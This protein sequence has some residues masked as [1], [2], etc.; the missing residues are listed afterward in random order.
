MMATT[1]TQAKIVHE[2]NFM[3]LRQVINRAGANLFKFELC[4]V[5]CYL[6]LNFNSV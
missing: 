5:L 6:Q 3:E 4:C 1:A 2:T